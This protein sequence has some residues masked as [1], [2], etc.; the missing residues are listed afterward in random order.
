MNEAPDELKQRVAKRKAVLLVG[1]GVS[2]RATGNRVASW[3]GLLEDG[4]G[5]CEEHVNALPGGWGDRVRADIASGDQDDLLIAAEKITRKLGSPANLLW[6]LRDTIGTLEVTTRDVLDAIAA[7]DLPIMT[8]NY[9]RLL[10]AVTDRP[11]V[12]WR[13]EEKVQRV[14]AEDEPGIIHLHGWYED[15]ESIVLDI[16]SYE[17]VVNS[18]FMRTT[19]QSTAYYKSIVFIGFGSGLDDPNFSRFRL[20]IR[21]V[22]SQAT[23]RHYRLCRTA[24]LERLVRDHKA[25]SFLRVLPFGARDDELATYLRSLAPGKPGLGAALHSAQAPPPIAGVADSP[26]A[27]PMTD[28]ERTRSLST[29]PVAQVLP[30]SA[31]PSYDQASTAQREAVEQHAPKLMEAYRRTQRER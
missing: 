6:W 14:L 11:P 2:A 12:H 26:P 8:T 29:V 25:D 27:S 16:R 15:P 9:D 17:R 31:Q 13:E 18:E 22:L 24:E 21:D 20:W 3:T 28:G 23:N 10:E 1:A 19:L 4:V 5:F 30:G 7:L